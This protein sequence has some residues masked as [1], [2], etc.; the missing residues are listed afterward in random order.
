MAVPFLERNQPQLCPEHLQST[1][2]FQQIVFSF[3]CS[4]FSLEE[5]YFFWIEFG[6]SHEWFWQVVYILVWF[7]L[8]WY[9][10]VRNEIV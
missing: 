10:F 8:V 3:I 4:I 5:V 9:G 6:H 2:Y 1:I 7:C